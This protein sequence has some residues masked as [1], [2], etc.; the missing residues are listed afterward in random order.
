MSESIPQ[1]E[2]ETEPQKPLLL[3][4]KGAAAIIW[5]TLVLFC[6]MLCFKISERGRVSELETFSE[7]TAVGDHSYYPLPDF[8]NR[9]GVSIL[10]FKGRPLY[11]DYKHVTNRDSRMRR[12]GAE[13][14]GKYQI[15]ID[16]EPV[17]PDNKSHDEP[18]Y[19][20]K[21]AEDEYVGLWLQPVVGP[22]A[23]R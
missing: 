8:T 15:Y 11:T 5:T 19:F 17:K 12:I 1:P 14:S 10:I 6:A 2:A 20:A 13:D 16:E 18:R 4:E 7:A 3:G 23:A 21:T 22:K 9:T